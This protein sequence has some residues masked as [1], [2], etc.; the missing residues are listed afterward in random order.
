[1]WFIHWWR[2]SSGTFNAD[3][4]TRYTD[5]TFNLYSGMR[6]ECSCTLN[7]EVHRTCNGTIKVY[8]HSRPNDLELVL[9]V[10]VLPCTQLGITMTHIIHLVTVNMPLSQGKTKL[11][12]SINFSKMTQNKDLQSVYKCQ[13]SLERPT[14][15]TADSLQ[16][17]EAM[18]SV[19]L[20]R[21]QRIHIHSGTEYILIAETDWARLD[22]HGRSPLWEIRTVVLPFTTIFATIT[23]LRMPL[24]IALKSP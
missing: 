15:C 11:Y 5:D 19:V 21:Q 2:Y 1:M 4:H 8:E 3:T 23:I 22:Q 9:T 16:P 14:V 24:S 6:I 18:R 13:K 20:N 10:M 17:W 12:E 7:V